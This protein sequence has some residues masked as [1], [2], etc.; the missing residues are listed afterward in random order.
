MHAIH[1][2]SILAAPNVMLNPTT[3]WPSIRVLIVWFQKISISSMEGFFLS[4]TPHPRGFSIPEASWYSPTPWNF[5][6]FSTCAPLPLRNSI[7]MHRKGYYKFL[8][9]WCIRLII[10][11]TN[12]NE[13]NTITFLQDF[14]F[15]AGCHEFKDERINIEI[16]QI[17]FH[18]SQSGLA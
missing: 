18:P 11:V 4:L 6:D 1:W 17:H 14:D 3:S 8:H 7:S 10:T 13:R 5:H 2:K 15:W 9:I 16:S 12:T